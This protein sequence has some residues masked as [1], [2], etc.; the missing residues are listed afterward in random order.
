MYCLPLET[1]LIDSVI[2]TPGGIYTTGY[3]MNPGR[4]VFTTG[5]GCS[6]SVPNI[7]TDRDT[8][9]KIYDNIYSHFDNFQYL[10]IYV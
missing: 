8:A 4:K 5:K 6:L 10:G 1:V 2:S 9:S 3:F 7:V